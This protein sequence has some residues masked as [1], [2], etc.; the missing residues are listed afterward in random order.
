MFKHLLIPTDLTDGLP[1]LTGYLDAIA[2]TG[3]TKVIFLH[4]CIIVDDGDKPRIREDKLSRARKILKLEETDIPQGMTAE[5]ILD[6]RRPADAILDTIDKHQI[7][8]VLVSRPI[9]SFLDEKLFG[10][11]TIAVMQRINVPVMVMRPQV[12]WVMTRDELCLR[13]Q[14]FFSHLLIPYDHGSSAQHVIEVIKKNVVSQP[15][16]LESCTLCW[17]VSDAGQQELAATQ[18]FNEAER[19]LVSVKDDL[20]KLGLV[21]ETV[22]VSGTPVVEAQK[23]AHDRDIHAVVVSSGSVGKIWELSIPSFAGEILRRSVYP[24]IYFPPAG[25]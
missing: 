11:T 14:N 5:V 22:I 17:V 9:R 6:N 16:G 19:V 18:Q 13:L 25:R 1:R 3:I 2:A 7:D 24:V 8:L 21:V 23:A 12:L 4:C 20:Q 15:K 10:S